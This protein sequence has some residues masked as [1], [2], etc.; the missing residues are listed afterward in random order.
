MAIFINGKKVAGF[1]GRQGPPG[2]DGAPG[3]EGSPGPAGTNG[4]TYTPSV[5]SDGILSWTNDAGLPNPEPV[6]IMGPQ[7]EPGTGAVSSFNGRTGEIEPQK[8]DYTAEMVGAA[9]VEQ[10][11]AAIQAA[12]L[13]SWEGSY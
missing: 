6:N 10:V 12:I 11:N 5:S 3:K 1:G 13:D 7:G 2:K 8:G 4:G 9:T